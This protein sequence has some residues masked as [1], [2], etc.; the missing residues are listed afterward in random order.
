MLK[1]KKINIALMGVGIMGMKHL[2]AIKKCHNINVTAIIEND[3][4]KLSKLNIKTNYYETISEAFQNHKI[5]G[6]IISTPNSEHL[7]NSLEV[8]E[9]KCPLLIEKPIATNSEDALKIKKLSNKKNVDVLVGHHRRH[10]PIIKKAYE[11]INKSVIGEIRTVHIN[12]Q[13]YKP[14]EYFESSIWKKEKGAGPIFV[15]LIHDLDL[16]NYF[17]GD[18]E[19]VYAQLHPAKR[20]YINEDVCGALLR[21]KNGIIGTLL[22][23]DSV[24]SPWSWELTSKENDIYPSTEE[25]CYFFGGSKGSLSLPGLKVWKHRNKP[26][27]FN[28]ITEK[29]YSYKMADPLVNQINHFCDI[30]NKTAKPI[31]GPDFALKTIRVIEAIKKS[32]K[33]QKVVFVH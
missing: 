4:K 9:K 12:C 19:S 21:F 6:V 11:I 16:I 3:K 32:A 22:V 28:P 13:M 23:S 10:N 25:N 7:K 29:K 31:I 30:I 17:C 20:G 27:W 8:I 5:D 24:V 26:H 33:N 18:I 1:N 2:E 14:D 15:N